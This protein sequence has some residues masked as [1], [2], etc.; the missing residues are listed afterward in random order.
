VPRLP[1]EF[2]DHDSL[3]ELLKPIRPIIRVYQNTLLRLK[4]KFA[5]VY[6]NIDITH[7]LPGSLTI[8]REGLSMRMPLIYKGLYEVC[9]LCRGESYQLDSCPK[10]PS[11]KKI[12]VV[13]QIFEDGTTSGPSREPSSSTTAQIPLS[14]NWVTVPQKKESDLHL[15]LTIGNYLISNPRTRPF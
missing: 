14:K 5:R 11:Q 13:V 9:P 2:W 8:A 7:P 6:L 1:W 15:A 12:Q 4:G 3:T 10:P